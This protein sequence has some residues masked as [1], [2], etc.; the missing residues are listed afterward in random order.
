VDAY[1]AAGFRVVDV[2]V[3][4]ETA[5]VPPVEP[6]DASRVRFA[7]PD[8]AGAVERVGREG[9]ALSRFHLDPRIDRAAADEIKA[10]WAGNFFRGARGDY[11]VVA[12]PPGGATAFLQLLSGADGVLTID[13]IAVA[14]SH[15]RQGLAGAM[16]RFAAHHCAGVKRLRV[17]TQAANVDSLRLYQRLGFVVASTAYVL[18]C[19]GPAS[20]TSVSSPADSLAPAARG[21]GPATDSLAPATRGRGPATD[22]LA[23]A[24]RGRGPG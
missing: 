15:R 19:H 16:I 24:T 20:P 7:R 8:D 2:S 5:G 22:S 4:L 10:Q 18:H 12:G 3:T 14:A 9:F 17:G 1:Q 6:Q 23:P 13:L 11:M 21:R